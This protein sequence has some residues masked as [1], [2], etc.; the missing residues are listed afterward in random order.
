VLVADRYLRLRD[1]VHLL[2][3]HVPL[4]P[5]E[6]VSEVRIRLV[7]FRVNGPFDLNRYVY[8]GQRRWDRVMC[9]SHQQR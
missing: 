2:F 9:Q 6:R 1:S 3:V 8:M 7:G 4:V 5:R